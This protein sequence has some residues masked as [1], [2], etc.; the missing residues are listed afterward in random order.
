MNK[1]IKTALV[2]LGIIIIMLTT[3]FGTYRYIM[4]HQSLERGDNGTIYSTVFGHTDTY[5]VEPQE[6]H[7]VRIMNELYDEFSN[8]E[9]ADDY[10][11]TREDPY[12][13]SI[14][15]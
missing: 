10:T 5:Y 2:A 1:H 7:T 13:I 6:D 3:M 14:T 12:T 15:Q 4:T 8:S 9:L 11:I